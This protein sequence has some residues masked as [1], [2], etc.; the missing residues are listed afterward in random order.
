MSCCYA[1]NK[2]YFNNSCSLHQRDIPLFHLPQKA[3]SRHPWDY[4]QEVKNTRF[5]SSFSCRLMHR[6][7]TMR[8]DG[9]IQLSHYNTEGGIKG[10]LQQ[11]TKPL[12]KRPSFVPSSS[13]GQFLSSLGQCQAENQDDQPL[14]PPSD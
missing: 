7:P 11:L 14:L 8:E 10:V 6:I 12:S 1:Q 3:S 5:I 2:E 4:H 13:K 9:N